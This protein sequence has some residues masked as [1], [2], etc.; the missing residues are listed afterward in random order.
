MRIEVKQD[1]NG[2]L[3]KDVYPGVVFKYDE[4]YYMKVINTFRRE[5]AEYNAVALDDSDLA[6]FDDNDEVFIPSAKLVI[7]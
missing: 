2:V 3:F 1:K 4:S 6:L 7:E 5:G